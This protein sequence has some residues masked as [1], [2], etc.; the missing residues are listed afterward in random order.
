MMLAKRGLRTVARGTATRSATQRFVEDRCRRRSLE[1]IPRG[2]TDIVDGADDDSLRTSRRFRATA[3]EWTGSGTTE[4]ASRLRADHALIDPLNHVPKR[5]PRARLAAPALCHSVPVV[6]AVC[7]SR[8][9]WPI[10]VR[11]DDGAGHGR[12]ALTARLASR[13]PARAEPGS[14]DTRRAL[15]DM[16]TPGLEG[17]AVA[18]LRPARQ[19]RAG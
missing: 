10:R 14:I 1:G 4:G 5:G 19:H 3:V 16:R 9:R 13:S 18:A 8:Q 11:H 7:M 6:L 12:C 15:D 2:E 17:V